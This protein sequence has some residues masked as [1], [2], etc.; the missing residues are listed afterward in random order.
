MAEAGTNAECPVATSFN[1]FPVYLK[2]TG[3]I[4]FA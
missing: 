3:A 1:D 4:N 2:P